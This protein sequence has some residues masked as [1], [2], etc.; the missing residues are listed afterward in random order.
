MMTRTR[1][2]TAVA[3]ALAAGLIAGM[4]AVAWA[5]PE[6]TEPKFDAERIHNSI[7]KPTAPPAAGEV[8]KIGP[9]VVGEAPPDLVPIQTED[10]LDGFL[11]TYDMAHL[12]P[13]NHKTRR[14]DE[15]TVEIL[16][17]VYAK[18]GQTVIGTW[19]AGTASEE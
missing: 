8:P 13:E 14:L 18:D 6:P 5:D 17:P 9:W 7:Q 12:S 15:N 3:T 19:A 4:G 2:V 1:T 10:G 11:R 16:I